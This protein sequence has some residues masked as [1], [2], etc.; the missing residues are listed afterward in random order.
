MKVNVPID[1]SRHQSTKKEKT[2]KAHLKKTVHIDAYICF[3]IKKKK[4]LFPPAQVKR[5]ANSWTLHF[6]S[7][8]AKLT[9]PLRKD[10]VL[11]R[12]IPMRLG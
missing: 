10:A 9:G 1:T 12:G 8:V 5:C 3:N 11:V 2:C 4:N 7:S 6:K